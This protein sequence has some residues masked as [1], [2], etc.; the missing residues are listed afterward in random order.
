MPTDKVHEDDT[1]ADQYRALYDVW[2]AHV[3]AIEAAH[4]QPCNR[5]GNEQGKDGQR[6]VVVH[7]DGCLKGQHADE[8]HGP[9]AAGQAAG[10]KYVPLP[11]GGR[12]FAVGLALGHVE[13]GETGCAGYYVGE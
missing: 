13:G 12:V 8:M 5:Q 11:V 3:L 1:H 2:R 10:A 4:D 6:Q 9:D 7:F